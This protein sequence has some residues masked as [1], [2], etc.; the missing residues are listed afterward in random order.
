[1]FDNSYEDA[2]RRQ[3]KADERIEKLNKQ[4]QEATQRRIQ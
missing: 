3:H 4:K 1:M 2:Q